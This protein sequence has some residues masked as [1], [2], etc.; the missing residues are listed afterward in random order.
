[1]SEKALTPTNVDGRD[2]RY[3]A[4]NKVLVQILFANLAVTLVKIVVGLA[5]GV[6]AVVAD[7]FHSMVDSSSNLIGMAAIRLA[8]RPAD[9]RHPYGYQRYETLGALAIGLMMLLAAWEIGSAIVQRYLE[10]GTPELNT[11]SLVLVFLT[12]PVNL[13]VVI[14]EKRAGNRLKSQILLADAKHTQTDLYVTGSVLLSLIG[15]WFGW[16]WLDLVVAAAVVLLIVRA[17]LGIL[18]DASGGLADRSIVDAEEATAVALSVPGVRYVHHVRSR[19]TLESAYV[20]LHIKVL[21]GMPTSRAHA[22]ATEVERRLIDQ[23][24]GVKEALVH[25]EPA[26]GERPTLWERISDD[27]SGLAEGLGLGLHDLHIHMGEAETYDVEVHLEFADQVHLKEAH[28]LADHF[29]TEA[30]KRWPQIHLINTHLEP[31]PQQVLSSESKT[32]HDEENAMRMK[33]E[34]CMQ[35][36]K[37]EQFKLYQVDGHLHAN[38]TII[39]PGEMLLTDVHKLTEELETELRKQDPNLFRVNLHVEPE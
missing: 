14:L 6:L 1:M 32:G 10:G 9:E 7:G 39:L 2:A 17:A 18:R 15:I 33:L 36:G 24:G 13:T 26:K 27:L 37:I 11:I 28:D 34:A 5:T 16:T 25:I 35:T 4:V 21:P 8:R 20:D 23:V 19:G 22:I 38:V 12:F 29:E 30:R 3:S 31:L